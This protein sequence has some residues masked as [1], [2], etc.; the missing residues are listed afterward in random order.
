M[1]KLFK[2]GERVR[3]KTRTIAGWNGTGTVMEDQI[4]PDHPVHIWKDDYS[5]FQ[6]HVGQATVWPD[7][8]S[9]IRK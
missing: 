9:R 1:R 7:Q 3:L 2:Q 5:P 4:A 8:L 6:D